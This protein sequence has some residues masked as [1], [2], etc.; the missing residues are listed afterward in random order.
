MGVHFHFAAEL[1]IQLK[2]IVTVVSWPLAPNSPAAVSVPHLM[3][4][5]P[6]LLQEAGEDDVVFAG[7]S[8]GGNIALT[9]VLNALARDPSSPVPHTILAISPVVDCTLRNPQMKSTD[10]Y[11]PWLSTAYIDQCATRWCGSDYAREDP[12]ISPLYADLA[13]LKRRNV[14]LHGVIGT[15]DV[16]APDVLLLIEKA[17]KLDL[18]GSWLVWEKQ[19]HVFPLLW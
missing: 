17:Q 12:L 6:T 5:Y 10:K 13:A 14:K 16:L 1:A 4:L 19:M 3:R 7:D 8:A 2:C 15:Y 11:D 18:R 9:L